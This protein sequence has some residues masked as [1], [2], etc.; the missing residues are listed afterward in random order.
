MHVGITKY[1]L[2]SVKTL[3]TSLSLAK[4]SAVLPFCDM[5]KSYLIKQIKSNI[6]FIEWV[7]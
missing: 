7:N 4:S 6:L 2:A 1:I 3:K 5:E